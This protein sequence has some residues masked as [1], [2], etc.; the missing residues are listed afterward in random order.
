[1][2]STSQNLPSV[3]TSE[4]VAAT[5]EATIV[6]LPSHPPLGK[7]RKPNASGPRKTSAAWDHFIRLPN[8]AVPTA[9]CKHCHKRYLCD[10]KAHGTSNFLTHCKVCVKNPLNDPKQA[11]LIFASGELVAA[12]QRYNYEACRKAIALFV[13]LDE[14]AFR[15]VEGEGFKLMCRQL[16]PLLTVPSRR[17]VARDCFKLFVDEKVRLKA[18]FKSDCSRV[19]LTTDCWTSVQ[20]LSYMTLTAHFINNDW[21]YEKR[22]LSFCS[23]PNH[24]GDTIVV[25]Y[26]KK[27]ISNMGGLMGDGSFFH[28]RCCAHILNL[29]VGD[30]LKQN[31]LSISSVRNVVRFV[32]SSSQRSTKFKECIEFA[33]INCKKLLCL[34]VQTRWNSAYLML[35]TA[36]KFQAAFEKLEGEDSSYL[37]FFGE[38]GPP[39]VRDWEDVRCFV[40]FLKNFY[41]AT[42]EF[43]SSQEVSLHKAFHQLAVVHCELKRTTRN[44]NTILASMGVDMKQ[45]YDKYWDDVN[46][47]ILV[48]WKQNSCR[49]PV[50]STMVRDVLASPVSTVASE[51][52]L[53]TG[54]RVLDTYRSSLNPQMVEALICGQNWLKPTLSQFKDLNINDEFELSATIVSE[55]EGLSVCGSTSRG[56]TTATAVPGEASTSQS[57][58]MS[59]D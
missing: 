18:Y 2:E 27:R 53:S 24:K 37:D 58:P 5:T 39:S 15:V 59:Y 46:F 1:M 57:Q 29:V 7:R 17:T 10:P 4:G 44:L 41:D 28:L 50:L 47:D 52:A 25:A 3:L 19:A 45:K 8:E 40:R 56:I 11:T 33:R 55:F 49:Y 20:N 26:L 23:V 31:E 12:S 38:V 6:G 21:K 34:D 32:R 30:G 43:S 9:A 48:W 36:E 51:S 16:Q 35:E 22:I 54:G 14:H 13:I 42:N